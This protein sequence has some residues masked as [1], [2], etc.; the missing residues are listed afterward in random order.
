MAFH[1]DAAHEGLAKVLVASAPLA[2]LC[3]PFAQ[4]IHFVAW[5][6][7]RHFAYSVRASRGRVNGAYGGAA[8][9][10]LLIVHNAGN[11]LWA[12]AEKTADQKPALEVPEHLGDRHPE[13][14]SDQ[15]DIDQ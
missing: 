6:V 13:G 11:G 10:M 2:L 12:R 14:V 7:R 3:G 15:F 8:A 4:T 5:C 9:C 1:A